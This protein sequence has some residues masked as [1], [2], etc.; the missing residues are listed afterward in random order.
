[1]RFITVYLMI[2]AFNLNTAKAE[3]ALPTDNP[4]Y[5][6]IRNQMVAFGFNEGYVHELVSFSA[7]SCINKL[8]SYQVGDGLYLVIRHKIN[9]E[10]Y[11]IL[12]FEELSEPEGIQFLFDLSDLNVNQDCRVQLFPGGAYEVDYVGR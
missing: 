12:S 6:S 1:M 8:E 10:A 7:E 5:Q 11:D 2:A 3:V 4:N 9:T